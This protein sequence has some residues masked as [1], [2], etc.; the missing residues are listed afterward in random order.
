MR[1]AALLVFIAAF[2]PQAAAAAKGGIKVLNSIPDAYWGRGR[3][4]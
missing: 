3:P 2:V 4:V 1:K